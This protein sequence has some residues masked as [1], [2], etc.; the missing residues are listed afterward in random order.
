[1]FQC[2]LSMVAQGQRGGLGFRESWLIR[3]GAFQLV[4]GLLLSVDSSLVSDYPDPTWM[5]SHP[6][7]LQG[8]KLHSLENQ[9][10]VSQQVLLTYAPRLALIINPWLQMQ[11]GP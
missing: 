5:F 11:D 9:L 4:S 2:C 1:M 3:L 7:S 8:W 10:E 6:L